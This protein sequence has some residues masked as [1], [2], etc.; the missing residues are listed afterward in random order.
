[1]PIS[2]QHN[3]FIYPD[4]ISPLP[5]DD[6]IK[7][8][9]KKQEMFDEGVSKVQS[10]IDAYSDLRNNMLTSAEKEYFDQSMEGMVKAINSSAGVDFSIKANT[11]AVLNIG[12]PLEKDNNIITAIKSGKEAQRRAEYLSKLDQSKRS[13]TNDLV[14][15][16]DIQEKVKNNKVG[17][18]VE[19]GKEYL[20][21]TDISEDW[22][23]FFKNLPV[24]QQSEI[25]R[26]ASTP[27]GYFEMV[28]TEGF[29]KTK[30]ADMFRSYLAT[31]PKAL[32]QLQIDTQAGL[33]QMG[34]E[35]AHQVYTEKMGVQAKLAEQNVFSIEKALKE[36][37]A[38]YSKVP[39]P[40]VKGRVQEL[41]SQLADQQQKYLYAK[42]EAETTIDK[43][44]PNDVFQLYQ[45][46]LINNMA[47]LYSG[48]KVKR[49]LKEDKG[50]EYQMG[51]NKELFK[52][53]LG[54]QKAKVEKYNATDKQYVVNTGELGEILKRS[55]NFV[56]R[57]VK[58][59]NS[60]KNN[61]AM[62][63]ALKGLDEPLRAFKEEKGLKQLKALDKI[64][65]IIRT[66]SFG[67]DAGKDLA[68]DLGLAN[69]GKD[70]KDAALD[71]KES[72]K[73]LEEV[74]KNKD[75][76]SRQE[77]SFNNSFDFTLGSLG[78]FDFIRNADLIGQTFAIAAPDIS[79]STKQG[80]LDSGSTTTTTKFSQKGSPSNP[81][82]SYTDTE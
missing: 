21:F 24:D 29:N 44:N 28:T 17:Q 77:I 10:N 6:F 68:Y 14:F 55:K 31:N 75:F 53:N 56:E 48:Q 8:A 12:K 40:I 63:E 65:T 36:T 69:T 30:V 47:N 4:Y 57:L 2:A 71:A 67:A 58:I 61:D 41:K 26:N 33:I 59:Q 34:T 42:T 22:S 50:W 23:K 37:E 51:L 9:I 7:V 16:N 19:Y 15:M 72:I 62:Q 79:I 32:Q 27:Q 25:T 64:L 54:L 74:M 38:I 35:G 45:N 78:N 1:M 49:D 73:Q 81:A 76:N 70:Y 82:A 80:G 46:D 3:K 18:G 39:T 13:K 11:Q 66:T 52:H 43:F 20:E 60:Y 5:A